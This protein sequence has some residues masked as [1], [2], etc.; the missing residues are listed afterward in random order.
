MNRCFPGR[1]LLPL[2]DLSNFVVRVELS[3]CINMLETL[4]GFEHCDGCGP[5]IWTIVW[6]SAAH[7][8]ETLRTTTV[9]HLG[10]SILPANTTKLPHGN[11]T[12]YQSWI[13][14]MLCGVPLV[15]FCT[16]ASESVWFPWPNTNWPTSVP[17]LFKVSCSNFTSANLFR[18]WRMELIDYQFPQWVHAGINRAFLSFFSFVFHD[19]VCCNMCFWLHLKT[20][21]VLILRLLICFL[22]QEVVSSEPEQQVIMTP[23]GEQIVYHQD[24]NLITTLADM[25]Q[26][27]KKLDCVSFSLFRGWWKPRVGHSCDS[28]CFFSSSRWRQLSHSTWPRLK[29]FR[30]SSRCRTSSRRKTMSSC[31]KH[32]RFVFSIKSPRCHRWRANRNPLHQWFE[33]NTELTSPGHNVR[34]VVGVTV[35]IVI[36]SVLGQEWGGTNEQWEHEPLIGFVW[37]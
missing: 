34:T 27:R 22:D 15:S 29:R 8:C 3:D 31:N 5:V 6:L 11:S 14:Y 17:C 12:C 18:M 36:V 33:D 10:I 19:S 32:Q 28:H 13:S 9:L 16:L 2:R 26:V 37:T 7:S 24:Q 21:C 4:F 20:S 35:W 1:T 23:S 25:N 30:S